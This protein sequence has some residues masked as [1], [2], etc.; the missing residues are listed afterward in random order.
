MTSL[1]ETLSSVMYGKPSGANAVENDNPDFRSGYDAGMDCKDGIQ[2]KVWADAYA[3]YRKPLPDSERW[4]QWV[5]WK[6]GFWAAKF[7]VIE[8]AMVEQA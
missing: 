7:Q 6:R 1:S 5:E 2:S 8:A 4:L 3:A